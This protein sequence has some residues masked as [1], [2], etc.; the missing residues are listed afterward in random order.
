MQ[1]QGIRAHLVTRGMSHDFSRVASGTWDIFSCD[2]GDGP[3]KV[4]YVQRHQD[5]CLLARDSL[6]FPSRHG[7]T[8]GTLVK[9][10]WWPKVPFYLSQGYWDSYQFSRE[11]SHLLILKHLSPRDSRVIKGM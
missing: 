3:S 7:S 6:G 9:G 4:M 5:S 11:V 8:T 2:G 10:S 1:C